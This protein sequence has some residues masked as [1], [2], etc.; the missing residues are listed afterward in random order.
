VLVYGT[1]R[2]CVHS[3]FLMQSITA[4][5]RS[6]PGST[7]PRGWTEAAQETLTVSPPSTSSVVPVM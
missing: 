6:T 3:T 5:S 1:A 4:P 7:G 2:L